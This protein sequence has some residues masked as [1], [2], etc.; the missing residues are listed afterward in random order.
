MPIINSPILFGTGCMT[1]NRS[2]LEASTATRTSQAITYPGYSYSSSG[3]SSVATTRPTATAASMSLT[4]TTPSAAAAAAAAAMAAVT[5]PGL[6]AAVAQAPP[7][8]GPVAMPSRPNAAMQQAQSAAVQYP[9]AYMSASTMVMHTQ[10]PPTAAA[11]KQPPPELQDRIMSLIKTST[12]N[13]G[14]SATSLPPVGVPPPVPVPA[15]GMPPAALMQRNGNEALYAMQQQ[16]QQQLAKDKA[17][18]GMAQPSPY[19]SYGGWPQ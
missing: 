5:Y 18:M 13:P 15:P 10:P 1:G 12:V 6:T 17:Q 14:M 19:M 8:T 11:A 2:A 9:T 7:P 3:Y 16:Q 4:S